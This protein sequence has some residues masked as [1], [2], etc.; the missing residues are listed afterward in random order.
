MWGY[1]MMTNFKNKYTLFFEIF[2]INHNA[3]NV[4]MKKKFFFVRNVIIAIVNINITNL[5][6]GTR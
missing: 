6:N 1:F 4:L 2:W 3:I 5:L